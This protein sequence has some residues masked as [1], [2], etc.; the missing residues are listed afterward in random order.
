MELWVRV[1]VEEL[2]AHV[3]VRRKAT[4]IGWLLTV[5]R[6]LMVPLTIR[7]LLLIALATVWLL[8]GWCTVAALALVLRLLL[9]ESLLVVRPLALLTEVCTRIVRPFLELTFRAALVLVVGLAALLLVVVVVVTVGALA[10][11]IP[12]P[13]VSPI[14]TVVLVLEALVVIGLVL[15]AMAVVV[16]RMVVLIAEVVAV[17]EASVDV[18]DALDHPD[19]CFTPEVAPVHM[20][21]LP[22]LDFFRWQD[23]VLEESSL[24]LLVLG[25]V[26]AD[27]VDVVA[28]SDDLDVVVESLASHPLPKALEACA[29]GRQGEASTANSVLICERKGCL[30]LEVCKFALLPV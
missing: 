22:L 21:D 20:V 3:R 29:R 7:L 26:V 18:E 25:V 24:V 16:A 17:G 6:L 2:A 8:L 14:I 13:L 4:L 9:G 23:T 28:L 27:H 10:T 30:L 12:P 15:A 19:A 5:R 1:L 11:R